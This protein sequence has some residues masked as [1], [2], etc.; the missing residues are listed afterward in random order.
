MPTLEH[1]FIKHFL[2]RHDNRPTSVLWPEV[3]HSIVNC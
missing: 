3:A 1:T 2:V